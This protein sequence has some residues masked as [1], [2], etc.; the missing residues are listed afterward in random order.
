RDGG[1]DLFLVKH[2]PF[3][4]LLTLVDTKRY[5]PD[6]PVGVGVV[7]QLFGVVEAKRASAG[8]V[9]TTSFFS[10]GARQFQAEVPFRLGLQD[11]LDVHR[12]LQEA[13]LRQRRRDT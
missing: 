3:G 12:M 5:G 6:R 1:V 2:A 11:F 9:T 4:R 7:R 10:K 13:E 8:V